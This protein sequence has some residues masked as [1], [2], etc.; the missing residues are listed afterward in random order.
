MADNPPK[1]A[2]H[3]PWWAIG[4]RLT[5][6]VFVFTGVLFAPLQEPR[7]FLDGIADA[8]RLVGGVWLVV[9]AHH[10]FEHWMAGD[11]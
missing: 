6:A 11:A 2:A 1:Q 5:S 9:S 4:W 7:M 3:F 10:L 8:A